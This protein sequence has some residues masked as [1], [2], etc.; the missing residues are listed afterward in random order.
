MKNYENFKN[1]TYNNLK[2]LRKENNDFPFVN[3][4]KKRR[5]MYNVC[6]Q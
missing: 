5:D 1:Q 2:L 4:K 6:E 3:N